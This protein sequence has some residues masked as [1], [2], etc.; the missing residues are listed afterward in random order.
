MFLHFVLDGKF[1]DEFIENYLLFHAD[2]YVVF[3][4]IAEENNTIRNYI[5][6]EKVQ[7]LS[8][9]SKELQDIL[10]SIDKFDYVY[11]HSFRMPYAIDILKIIP[12]KIK[13]I[14]IFWGAEFYR[15]PL[16]DN[17]YDKYS[18]NYY[19]KVYKTQNKLLTFLPFFSLKVVLKL[20]QYVKHY[21]QFKHFNKINVFMHWNKADYLIVKKTLKN[22]NAIF[23]KFGYHEKINKNV[24]IPKENIDDF[25]TIMVGN[26]ATLSNNHISVFYKLK[27]LYKE[28]KFK[29]ICPLN[30]GDSEYANY[31][32]EVGKELYG[33]NFIAL[34]EFIEK[35]EYYKLF[36]KIDCFIMN[37]IRTQGG[38]NIIQAFLKG[39]K[40]YLNNENTQYQLFKDM[41]MTLFSINQIN[42]TN[43]DLF[44]SLDCEAKKRNFAIISAFYSELE[45]MYSKMP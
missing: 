2:Q 35:Q 25:Y 3:V 33:D 39:K 7:F 36:D 37:N 20:Y 21:Q 1:I 44:E 40:V 15:N 29:I 14:W 10:C 28:N 41:G 27:E 26:S 19:L 30:Y 32:I 45:S 11:F 17:I 24:I 9:L 16:Y 18:E 4:S 5:K 38:A 23:F 34:T 12:S 42:S 6:N 43:H 31:V 8:F 22:F 13:C